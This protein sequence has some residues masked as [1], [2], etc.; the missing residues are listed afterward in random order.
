[1]AK[2]VAEVDF[3]ITFNQVGAE[4]AYEHA[5]EHEGERKEFNKEYDKKIKEL[6][7]FLKKN[8]FSVIYASKGYPHMKMSNP[9]EDISYELAQQEEQE[10]ENMWSDTLDKVSEE[11]GISYSIYSLDEK[12]FDRVVASGDVVFTYRGGWGKAWQSD[13][14]KSP[15]YKDAWKFSDVAIKMS[16]D[17]HHIFFE[18][19]R[20]AKEENGVKYFEFTYGS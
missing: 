2:F 5:S 19:V 16:E 8:G 14:I 20:L 18:S 7:E 3:K 13:I 17:H 6:E 11:L 15:T 4:F 12:D 1:M 10:E 9:E